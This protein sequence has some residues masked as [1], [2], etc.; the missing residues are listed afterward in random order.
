M[1]GRAARP[2]SPHPRPAPSQPP[3]RPPWATPRR[4]AAAAA[5]SAQAPVRST[6][7]GWRA[8]GASTHHAAAA[9]LVAAGG[10]D[11]VPDRGSHLPLVRLE[12]KAGAAEAQ[13]VLGGAEFVVAAI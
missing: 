2:V 4:P 8:A 12:V 1:P 3:A 13:R 5:A 7:A 11:K 9:R 6:R 10:V